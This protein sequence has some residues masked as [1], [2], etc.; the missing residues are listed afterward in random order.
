MKNSNSKKFSPFT[1]LAIAIGLLLA[2][3]DDYIVEYLGNRPTVG[4]L[5][6]GVLLFSLFIIIKMGKVNKSKS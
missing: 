2:F 6:V 1:L 3:T 4:I 5:F